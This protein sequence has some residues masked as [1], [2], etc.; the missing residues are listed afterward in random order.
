MLDCSSLGARVWWC[1]RGLGVRIQTKL[2]SSGACPA[3]V[4]LLAAREGVRQAEHARQA[5]D[6]HRADGTSV[7]I[8]S[9][10]SA[11][12]LLCLL[13]SGCVAHLTL[14]AVPHASARCATACALV[15]L[16]P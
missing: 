12:S 5:V 6:E 15:P 10:P 9:P 7:R 14:R 3:A 13:S 4:C 2:T 11:G 8:Q 16:F 1:M